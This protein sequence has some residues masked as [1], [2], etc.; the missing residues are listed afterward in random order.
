M[1]ILDG[2]FRGPSSPSRN[3]PHGNLGVL[4]IAVLGMFAI[5]TIRL[6]SMQIIDGDDY[7]R[8]SRENHIRAT[9]ILPARGLIF[10]RNG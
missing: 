3:R 5:L 10:D 2:G 4:R 8:R 9:N 7:A 6:V 1:S